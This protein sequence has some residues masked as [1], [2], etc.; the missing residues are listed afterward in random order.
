MRLFELLDL[1]VFEWMFSETASEVFKA[2]GVRWQDFDDSWPAKQLL[3]NF[4]QAKTQHGYDYAFEKY[5]DQAI[6]DSFFD[7][8]GKSK[9]IVLAVEFKKAVRT[10]QAQKL[11]KQ[12]QASPETAD[13][14]IKA[15]Q[16]QKASGVGVFDLKDALSD[17]VRV[18]EQRVESGKAIVALPGW[19]SLSEAV[20]GFNPGRV[21]LLV[22]KT[23]FGKTNLGLNLAYS[24]SK[25]MPVLFVN[26]EMLTQDIVE[27]VIF[28]GAGITAKRFRSGY[29]IGQIAEWYN[30]VEQNKSFFLTDGKGL[31]IEEIAAVLRTKRAHDDIHIAFVDY[32]QKIKLDV[33]SKTPEWKALQIAVEKLEE[34]AKE[35]EIFIML[36]AQ[37]NEEGGPSGSKRSLYPASVVLLFHQDDS[38]RVIIEAIKNRFGKRGVKIEC[39]YSPENSRVTEIGLI[40]E[41]EAKK[42]GLSFGAVAPPSNRGPR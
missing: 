24:A 9:P 41:K 10:F 36:M 33:D 30:E 40:E 1:I 42:Q 2:Q 18:N 32:D 14:L 15:Y 19:K 20:S 31:S 27:R 25:A 37:A 23:G 38:G 39:E 6:S 12:I 17:C 28:L 35:L 16:S 4:E 29:G 7:S 8:G 22:A 5:S 3:K 11:A 21:G 34:L 13:A 26:M